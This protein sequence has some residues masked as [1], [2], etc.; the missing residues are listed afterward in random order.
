MIVLLVAMGRT[1]PGEGLVAGIEALQRA[2]VTVD[3]LSRRPPTAE[4]AE[5]LNAVHAVPSGAPSRLPVLTGAGRGLPGPLA[6]VRLDADRLPGAVRVL[7]T[8]STRAL[9]ARADAV[10]AVDQAAVPLAWLALRR[11]PEL[12]ALSGLPAAV[13][14][15]GR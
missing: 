5:R 4:L 14:R 6:K 1:P 12:V 15:W 3:L 2:G 11:R 7:R 10:V 13:T 8:A 9:L